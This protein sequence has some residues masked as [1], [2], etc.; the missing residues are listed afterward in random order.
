MDRAFPV[1]RVP[2]GRI[3]GTVELGIETDFAHRIID[4]MADQPSGRLPGRAAWG[5]AHHPDVRN[6]TILN[7]HLEFRGTEELAILA[8]ANLPW[9]PTSGRWRE[10]PS[11]GDFLAGG[12]E[13]D[14]VFLAEC[15]E[16]GGKIAM[17][18]EIERQIAG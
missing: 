10:E 15:R 12:N 11:S 1:Y 18:Q 17:P 2:A 8:K 9:K 14:F 3:G 16:I 7:L 13:R 6:F 5:T 4:G